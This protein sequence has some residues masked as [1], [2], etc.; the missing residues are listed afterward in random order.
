M[1]YSNEKMRTFNSPNLITC[2]R[3]TVMTS[4]HSKN[5][6]NNDTTVPN[7]Y[8]SIELFQRLGQRLVLKGA[9][10]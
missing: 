7:G 4:V 5:P 10:G 1:T 6:S 8:T 9:R 3:N 2:T